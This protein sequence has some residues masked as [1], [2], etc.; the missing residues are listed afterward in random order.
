ME[1]KKF[2]YEKF[3]T[4][5]IS[6]TDKKRICGYFVV[7]DLHKSNEVD[8]RLRTEELIEEIEKHDD[9]I[10]ES[11]IWDANH[12]VD[13]NREGLNTILEKARNNEFDILL[14]HHVTLISRQGSKTFDYVLQLHK[15]NKKPYG[16]IDKIHSFDDLAKSLHLTVAN[17]KK[18]EEIKSSEV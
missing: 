13:T 3:N 1:N 2:G 16:I 4:E 18:Y 17:R 6:G 9:W 10:L 5:V 12:K 14:L 11:I 7:S 8:I 15:L